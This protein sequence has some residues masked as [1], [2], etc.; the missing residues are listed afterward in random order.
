MK[1]FFVIAVLAVASL[2]AYAQPRAIGANLGASIGFSYQHGFGESNMLDIAVYTPLASGRG[3]LWGL[4]A[5]I[6]YDWID[7]FGAKVPWN[8]KGE[9]HWYMGVGGAGGYLFNVGGAGWVGAAGHFGIEYDFWFPFQLSLDWRPCIGVTI[10]GNGV[11]FNTGGL[12]DGITLGV[13]YK[14]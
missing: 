13:R 11:G 14:F 6:T 4:G 5:H 1:K 3:H 10:V 8:E 9:W 7:P 2:A 12:Y